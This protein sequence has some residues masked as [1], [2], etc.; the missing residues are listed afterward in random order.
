MGE[1]GGPHIVGWGLN[2]GE[3]TCMPSYPQFIFT[4]STTSPHKEVK[5]KNKNKKQSPSITFC[6][7][8]VPLC[9]QPPQVFHLVCNHHLGGG[10]G[11][12]GE[13]EQKRAVLNVQ[14]SIQCWINENASSIVIVLTPKQKL[15]S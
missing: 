7:Q 1:V 13:R 10:G 11:G 5:N 2:E 12:A 6:V 14:C 15:G 9:F 4:V 8:L 3:K